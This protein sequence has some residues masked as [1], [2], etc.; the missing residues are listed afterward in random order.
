MPTSDTRWIA[1]WTASAQARWDDV[2]DV[3]LAFPRHLHGHTLQQT[4]RLSL[5]GERARVLFSNAHGRTPL[6]I[7]AASA[8]LRGDAPQPLRFAGQTSA[9]IAPGAALLSDPLDG[10]FPVLSSLVV[11]LFLPEPTPCDTFH[12]DARQTTHLARGDH[13]RSGRFM[14]EADFTSR[15]FLAAVWVQ[16][17]AES[18]AV[19][20]LADSIADGDGST[21]DANRR[22]P[23]RLAERLIVAGQPAAVLNQGI[24]GNRLLADGMGISGLARLERDVIAQ[25]GVQTVLMAL[26]LNDIGWPGTPQDPQRP[27]PELPA[28][29]LGAT[30]VAER[31]RAAGLRVIGCTL[32]PFGGVASAAAPGAIR[33]TEREALRRAYN[34]WLRSSPA[35]DA[36]V[37]FANAVC[38]PAHPNQLQAQ[39]DSGDHLHLNDRGYLAMG[40]AIDLDQLWARA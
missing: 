6:H 8:G 2:L 17:A 1:S 28:L 20:V 22:W 38:D 33:D 18:R 5:G 40:D 25:P 34:A 3:P 39:F 32:T 15:L 26:G 11:N 23:D 19:V 35:F 36:V 9:Q 10:P 4:L 14:S 37:D 21:V 13:T 16:A 24:S 12:W 30:Q 31:C 7:G 27:L 29:Q